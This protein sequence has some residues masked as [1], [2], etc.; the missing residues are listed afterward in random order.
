MLADRGVAALLEMAVATS[1]L[2][3]RVLARDDG[4]RDLTDLRHIGQAL[5]EAATAE[6]GGVAFLVEWLQHRRVEAKTD[7]EEERSRR[8]DSDATAVQVLTVHRSKGLQFPVVYVPFLWDRYVPRIPDSAAARRRRRAASR[9]RRS[10]GPGYAARRTVYLR[11]GCGGV[12]AGGVRLPD[13]GAVASGHLL[14]A[15][16]TR[17][18]R[19][20]TGC[21]SAT[22]SAGRRTR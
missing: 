18:R 15:D 14:G 21:C 16:V 11:G 13:P 4:E 5:H 19:R 6:N 12:P 9:R 10:A 1:G 7:V 3:E 2:V 20:C 8:L 22:R 17:L